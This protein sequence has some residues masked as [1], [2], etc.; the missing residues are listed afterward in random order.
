MRSYW[1][2]SRIIPAARAL[3][4]GSLLA[5]VYAAVQAAGQ[6]IAYAGPLE[7][8]LIL[9]IGTAWGRRRRWISPRADTLGLLAGIV[10]AGAF[11][12]LLDPH[13]R[14]ALLDGQP[15]RALSL[16]LAGW[17][18]GGIAFWRGETHRVRD[19][20]SLI[21]DRLMRWAVPGLAVPWLIGH[22]VASGE[23][24]SHFAASAFLG[25]VLF[26]GAG[27]ITI[28]LARLESLR[29]ST[30]GYWS[31]DT[32]WML[33]VVGIAMAVTV[34]S[35][36][37]AAVLG[38][39]ANALLTV[40]AGPLQTLILIVA[41]LSAPAFLLAAFL[42]GL[43]PPLH[44][45]LDGFQIPSLQIPKAQPGSDLPLIILSVVVASLFLFE[46]IVM[47]IMLWVVVRDRGRRQDVVDPAFEERAT[48]IPA[49][50]PSVPGPERAPAP[51][52]LDPADPAAAYVLALEALAQDGRWSRN[53]AETPAAHLAR[54]RGAGMESGA[55]ARLA[56][57]YQLVRYGRQAISG[58][59]SFRARPRLASLRA[60]LRGDQ[61]P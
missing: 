5:V 57:A 21:D 40:L 7:L 16:H 19:D 61:H 14:G 52:A 48:V 58:R 49:R 3:A 25:T 29:R 47:G 28:G 10:I 23:I 45:S 24:E 32:S 9:A 35:V 20:D 41:L 31:R 22:S 44:H 27:L 54:V 12:W 53:P 34:V 26:V 43:I 51:S 8:G 56:A 37:V 13:V 50:Q 38:I 55:F 2:A 18:A 4:E 15:L 59:E 1:P 11:S 17:L 46:F 33:M 39:P 6:E 60:W 30:V 42:A 36:P